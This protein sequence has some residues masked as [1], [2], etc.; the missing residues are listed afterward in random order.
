[1]CAQPGDIIAAVTEGNYG[2]VSQMV[3]A[4]PKIVSTVDE[5]DGASV[6][7]WATLKGN[8][9]TGELLVRRGAAVEALDKE[10][11]TALHWAAV[12]NQTAFVEFLLGR[13]ADPR[14]KD[15]ARKTSHQYAQEQGHKELAALLEKAEVTG[16][17][18]PTEAPLSQDLAGFKVKSCLLYTSPSPRD[19]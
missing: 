5:R 9:P 15:G 16:P 8:V 17:V 14:R 11:R 1:M 19:S 2:V 6:L 3:Q 10:G 13:G 12:G 18:S 7:H 4:N